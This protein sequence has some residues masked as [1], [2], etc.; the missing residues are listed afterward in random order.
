MGAEMN[1]RLQRGLR[2]NEFIYFDEDLDAEAARRWRG[3]LDEDVKP[4]VKALADKYEAELMEHWDGAGL[5]ARIGLWLAGEKPV[6]AR[7]WS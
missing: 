2:D 7:W 1:D 6:G 4:L 5:F 3:K